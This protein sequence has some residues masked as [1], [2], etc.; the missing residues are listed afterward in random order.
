MK[1]KIALIVLL[2]ILLLSFIFIYIQHKETV[3]FM[4]L[5]YAKLIHFMEECVR[6]R[7]IYPV[8]DSKILEIKSEYPELLIMEYE[9]GPDSAGYLQLSAYN[10]KQAYSYGFGKITYGTY[11]TEDETTAYIKYSHKIENRFG[12][13]ITYSFSIRKQAP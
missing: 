9:S 7:K 11:Y 5:K 6:N 8:D 1:I 12:E 2:A 3:R 10:Y 13:L 4:E